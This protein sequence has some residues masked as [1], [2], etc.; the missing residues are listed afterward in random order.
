MDSHDERRAKRRARIK[1][2]EADLDREEA[3][4]KG[5][6]S[7]PQSAVVDRRKGGTLL[8][9]AILL[10][11][12]TLSIVLLGVGMTL[13]R[14]AGHDFDDAR[15]T[16]LATVASC[17]EKG[18][19]TDQ[20]FGYW[21]RCRITVRWDDGAD[22]E[23][24]VDGLFTGADIGRELRVGNLAEQQYSYEL[25]R[26][27]TPYRPWLTWVG[28]AVSLVGALPGLLALMIISLPLYY[29]RK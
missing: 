4:R 7:D 23:L 12:V 26:E 13:M 5:T 29:R 14:M 19:V 18:P 15:R 21:D 10:G 1:A 11:A 8:V 22:D 3:E 17:A 20:G 28:G 16:G 24:V 2:M 6:A 25:A 27:D 9:V